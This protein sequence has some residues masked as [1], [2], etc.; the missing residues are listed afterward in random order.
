MHD[1]G[2]SLP[3]AI[4][5]MPAFEGVNGLSVCPPMVCPPGAQDSS[6]PTT[7][8]AAAAAAAAAG[9]SQV[10]ARRAAC[11]RP[12]ARAASAAAA[13]AARSPSLASETPNPERILSAA[14]H[15][16]CPLQ[17]AAIGLGAMGAAPSSLQQMQMQVDG[18]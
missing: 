14:A 12:A 1:K 9:V 13:A 10:R 7:A 4:A 17:G 11:A 16:C 3:A 2:Q 5:H 8:A 18:K 6:Q 15:C